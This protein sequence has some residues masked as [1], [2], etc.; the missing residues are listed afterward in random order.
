L[1]LNVYFRKKNE[2]K[3]FF[4]Y[5]IKAVFFLSEKRCDY[6][7]DYI[8]SQV[9]NFENLLGSSIKLGFFLEKL[10]LTA[11]TLKSLFRSPFLTFENGV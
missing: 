1:I 6:L 8:F 9:I 7:N 5:S 2:R 4:K 3:I 10:R 11:E